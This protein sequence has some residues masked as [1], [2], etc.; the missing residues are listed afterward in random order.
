MEI[1]ALEILAILG[2]VHVRPGFA[3]AVDGEAVGTSPSL[4]VKT[5]AAWLVERCAGEM[6]PQNLSLTLVVQFQG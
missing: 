2:A 4:Q 6:K 1:V 3:R 5:P